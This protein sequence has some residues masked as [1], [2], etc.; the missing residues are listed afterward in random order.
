MKCDLPGWG[1]P[2][3]ELMSNK[4]L[5]RLNLKRSWRG[6]EAFMILIAAL[7]CLM[8]VYGAVHFD[9]RELRRKLYFSCYVL[10]FVCTVIAFCVN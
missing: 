2:K 10:L 9:F 6:Y 4:E 3:G 5:L 7:E 1:R 8:M